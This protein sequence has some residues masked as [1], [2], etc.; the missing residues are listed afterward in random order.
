MLRRSTCGMEDDDRAHPGGR[1]TP[2][3]FK[4]V[5]DPAFERAPAPRHPVRDTGGPNLDFE[6]DPARAAPQGDD[7]R[8]S[9]TQ[10][11]AAPRHHRH[12]RG[13][14][15]TSPAFEAVPASLGVAQQRLST[16]DHRRPSRTRWR[17]R[18]GTARAA[19]VG[20]SGRVKAHSCQVAV[21]PRRRCARVGDAGPARFGPRPI[22]M[23]GAGRSAHP[24]ACRVGSSW[25]SR[26]RC[27]W[28]G[29]LGSR[30][31]SG[32]A[33]RSNPAH[34]I[35][36]PSTVGIADGDRDTGHRDHHAADAE[37]DAAVR[38]HARRQRRL[39]R[40]RTRDSGRAARAGP[41]H[42]DEHQP[43]LHRFHHRAQGARE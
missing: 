30:A 29:S 5:H 22:R 14:R 11:R 7:A 3:S 27:S 6:D 21:A 25:A 10:E 17:W 38:R 13:R 35:T 12:R 24:R 33:G 20:T 40:G 34:T 41:E 36:T 26:S 16:P 28:S 18:T 23:G 42:R 43:V 15:S 2:L 1:R 39:W 32:S 4:K 37:G 9:N 8:S 19:A 31:T